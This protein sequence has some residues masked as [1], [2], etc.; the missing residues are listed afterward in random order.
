MK[1]TNIKNV[2][3]GALVIVNVFFL[4]VFFIRLAGDHSE[5]TKALENLSTLLGRNG[6]YINIDTIREGG[7]LTELQISRDTSEEQKIADTLLG[8]TEMTD[9]GGGI[10]IYAGQNGQAEFRNGGKFDITFKPQVY[11][12][13]VNATTTA[14]SLLR[15]M[16]VE[17]LSVDTA[18]EAGNETVVAICSWK[19]QPI[20]NCRITFVFRDGSLAR[21]SGKHAAN[22]VVTSNNTDMSSCATAIMHFLNDVKAGKYSCTQIKKVDP[23]YNFKATGDGIT[24]VWRIETDTGVYYIDAVTGIIEQDIQ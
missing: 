10:Y 11:G 4:A 20:F 12:M 5:K 13:T 21:I 7:E 17:T 24:A 3:I 6:V 16:N 9:Q 1:V 22:I 19:H 2:V 8:Q 23:G 15:T 18:G 14:R